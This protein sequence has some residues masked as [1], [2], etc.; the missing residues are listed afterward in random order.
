MPD[1]LRCDDEHEESEEPIQ[2]AQRCAGSRH[3]ETNE[4]AYDSA[5]ADQPKTDEDAGTGADELQHGGQR[6]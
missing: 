6:G 5:S 1:E 4:Q 2:G 3:D